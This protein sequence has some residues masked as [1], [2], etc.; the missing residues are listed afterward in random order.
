MV[1]G[2]PDEDPHQTRARPAPP[3]GSN[4][5]QIVNVAPGTDAGNFYE[6]ALLRRAETILFE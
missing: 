5:R 6:G 2:Q 4:P 1:L 3:R